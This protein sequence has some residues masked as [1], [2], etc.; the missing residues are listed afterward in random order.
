MLV[1]ETLP[2]ADGKTLG[3]DLGFAECSGYSTR[4]TAKRAKK[5]YLQ[6]QI[7]IHDYNFLNS[8]KR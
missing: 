6:T 7:C 3:K 5:I 1:T 8:Q 4:Q 2:S